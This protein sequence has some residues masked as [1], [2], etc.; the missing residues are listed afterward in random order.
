[1]LQE[2]SSAKINRPSC[3]RS[4]GR[5]SKPE[6]LQVETIRLQENAEAM[7]GAVT[8][9]TDAVK[10]QRAGTGKGP[11]M[12]DKAADEPTIF[13]DESSVHLARACREE[14]FQ[15]WRRRFEN[16]VIGSY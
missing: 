6:G 16:S 5:S 7:P 4:A 15:G 8:A 3:R 10:S 14:S 12:V 13:N 1:M 9:V 2:R 11:S